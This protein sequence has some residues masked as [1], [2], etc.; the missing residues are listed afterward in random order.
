MTLHVTSLQC[1][2]TSGIV[3]DHYEE[4]N[5][6]LLK[7]SVGFQPIQPLQILVHYT[8][9]AKPDGLGG[10]FRVSIADGLELK[11]KYQLVTRRT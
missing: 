10:D 9:T 7:Q 4:F 11:W 5:L 2:L 6:L 1:H 3:C 8:P